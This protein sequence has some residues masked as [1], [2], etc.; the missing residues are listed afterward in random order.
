MM[1]RLARNA[2]R[3][4]MEDAARR[5]RREHSR[6]AWTLRIVVGL[7]PLAGGVGTAIEIANCFGP[8]VGGRMSI[9]LR[10]IRDL[11]DAIVPILFGL[12]V[13]T[14]ARMVHIWIADQLDDLAHEMEIAGSELLSLLDG[15]HQ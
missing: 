9:Y 2:V 6:G 4:R 3:W 8:V 13:A 11:S 10:T 5:T 7:A 14:L 1:T 15:V 12:A